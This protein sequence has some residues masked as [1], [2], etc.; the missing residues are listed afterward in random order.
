MHPTIYIKIKTEN[1]EESD[2]HL[3]VFKAYM[4]FAF[5]FILFQ[6]ADIFRSPCTNLLR[7]DS[8]AG[9]ERGCDLSRNG[10]NIKSDCSSASEMRVFL[11]DFVN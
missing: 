11:F 10:I 9:G 4:F 1:N 5:F 7:V 3:T 6:L 8:W 2:N